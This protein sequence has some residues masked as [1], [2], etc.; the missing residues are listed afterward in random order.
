MDAVDAGRASLTANVCLRFVVLTACRSGEA[1]KAIW[2]EVDMDAVTWTNPAERMKSEKG[3]RVPLS[4]AALAVLRDVR[5][6]DDGSG[7]VFPWPQ[8]VGKA[9]NDMI[10]TKVLRDIGLAEQRRQT[11][12]DVSLACLSCL[13]TQ[14]QSSISGQSVVRCRLPMGRSPRLA[15]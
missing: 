3:H 4:D 12:S 15:V 2:D 5:P 9:M 14:R 7:L 6:L 10:L 1:R 11:Y 13:P 8:R